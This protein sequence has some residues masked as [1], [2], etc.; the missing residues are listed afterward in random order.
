MNTLDDR[1]KKLMEEVFLGKLCMDCNKPARRLTS[2]R[3]NGNN[4][5]KYFCHECYKK[6]IPIVEVH[7]ARDPRKL[8]ER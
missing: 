2:N 6:V 5:T 7:K 4:I 8:C 1:V 3:D